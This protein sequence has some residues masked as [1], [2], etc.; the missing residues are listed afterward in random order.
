MKTSS[1]SARWSLLLALMSM[2]TW[3]GCAS[4]SKEA[5]AEPVAVQEPQAPDALRAPDAPQA[6]LSPSGTVVP[7]QPFSPA[8]YAEHIRAIEAGLRPLTSIP[9]PIDPEPPMR[10]LHDQK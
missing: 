2:L 8:Y 1:A 7:V 3:N 9:A 10:Q 4:T 5:D 6:T